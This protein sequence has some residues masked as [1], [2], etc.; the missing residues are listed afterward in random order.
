[1]ALDR[2]FKDSADLQGLQGDAIIELMT[3][4]L[5]PL[6]NAIAPQDRYIRFVNWVVADG[7]SVQYGGQQYIA[8]PYKAEGFVIQTQ[9][10]PPNPLL[11]VSNVGLDFTALVN[12][13]DDLV[14][15]K[16]IRR[17]VLARHLDS[18]ASPDANA[19][20][21]DELWT[22]QQ[23]ETE[24]KLFVA[25]R[26][27]TAFDL[28]GITLPRRRA[29]RYTCPWTYRGEGCDY[30]GPPVAD[31][32]D[33]PLTTSADPLVQA[34]IATRATV[35]ATRAARSAAETAYAAAT[36]T[37]A[38][39]AAAEAYWASV[40]AA[41]A[42][43]VFAEE[44]YELTLGVFGAVFTYGVIYPENTA[45]S[46]ATAMWN[47]STVD[48]GVQYRIGSYRERRLSTNYG[49]RAYY[50]CYT[51]QRWAPDAAVSAA[52]AAQ[53]AAAQAALS[54]AVTEEAAKKADFDAAAAAFA[55]AIQQYRDAAAAWAAAPSP[56]TAGDACGK[57]LASCRL[58]FYDPATNAYDSLPF[59]G[60]PGLTI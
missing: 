49:A 9:G 24:N 50:H 39:A 6:D 48:L 22:V 46:P 21:P 45:G 16:L 58:R 5:Q 27:S 57:R 15:A 31:A 10:V 1:M 35:V 29:L 14:G 53:H 44:R 42:P 11:T 40:V 20:W 52:N 2:S 19:H 34:V 8:I 37:R 33:A 55:S 17:R 30:T 12:R 26:L 59:G 51:I 43:W 25:F 47:N 28:D 54:A 56:S 23:K 32:K 41:G 18:G 3:L 7:Q 36:T 60:F 13:W 38:N 4:D